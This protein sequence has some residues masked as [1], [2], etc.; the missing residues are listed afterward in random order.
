MSDTV[1]A[2]NAGERE[3]WAA[4]A[5]VADHGLY[6]PEWENA[7][8]SASN[9]IG[10][11]MEQTVWLFLRGPKDLARP[12]FGSW[13]ALP[14]RGR[15]DLAMATVARFGLDALPLAL[16]AAGSEADRLGL[17]LM[18]FA[19]P[20]PAALAAGWLGNLG[21]S[22]L[23]ARTWLTRH[24]TVAIRTLTPIAAG[25]PSRARQNAADALEFLRVNTQIKNTRGYGPAPAATN[26]SHGTAEDGTA[27]DRTA[28][29]AGTPRTASVTRPGK[30]PLWA[31]PAKLPLIVLAGEDAGTLSAD[32]TTELLA[33]L[34]RARLADPPEPP[35]GSYHPVQAVESSSAAQPLVVVDPPAFLADCDPASVAAFGRALLEAWLDDEMPAG[36]AWALLAQ[37]CLG[38]DATADRLAPL[39]RSWPSRSR[40]ARAVE[41]FAVLATIGSDAALRRLHE[42]ELGMSGGPTNDRATTYFTQAAAVRGLTAPELEDRLGPTFGLDAGVTLDYGPRTFTA[43]A[44]GTL[45]LYV[46]D[47]TGRR[48]RRPPKPGVRDAPDGLQR[49]T[50]LRKELRA[51]VS[52]QT[53]RL[54][55]DMLTGRR[56]TAGHLR[57]HVLPHPVLGPIARR[58]LWI[59]DGTALRIAEDGTFAD[60]HDHT[61]TLTDGTPVRLAHP[62]LVGADLGAWETTFLDYEIMQ[63]FPQLHRPVAAPAEVTGRALPADRIIGLE[64]FG[65]HRRGGG[66][67]QFSRLVHQLPDGLALVADVSP[68]FPVT[69]MPTTPD[70]TITELWVD[71]AFSDNWPTARRIPFAEADPVTLS[72]ALCALRD[73]LS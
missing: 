58:L 70:Q 1:L 28:A 11:T 50:Q 43:W 29:G 23:W 17:L 72:E 35:P 26:A 20:E 3:R 40:Y 27:P 45:T 10:L 30:M 71:R 24:E 57:G 41:G 44:D 56:R 2:W 59:A 36:H 60:I 4:R 69:V 65:W 21:S 14:Y 13:N 68:G 12:L 66:H 52:A 67:H 47:P 18:P 16:S 32:S 8:G 25:K 54:E 6:E 9:S 64:R 55:R 31:V 37:A 46:T 48:L 5:A 61:V 53:A 42:I 49:F 51:E 15:L 73:V 7:A 39:I 22:R 34:T 33:A 63:P 38:D 62:V 19:G